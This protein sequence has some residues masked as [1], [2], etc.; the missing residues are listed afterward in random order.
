MDIRHPLITGTPTSGKTSLILEAEEAALLATSVPRP[1]ADQLLD[2][3]AGTVAIGRHTDG[4][5]ALLP[6]WN[7]YGAAHTLIA[8]PTGS[9]TSTLLDHLAAAEATTPLIDSRLIDG[10]AVAHGF[11]TTGRTDH[12]VRTA[13]ERGQALE[14]LGDLFDT[15]GR[16]R[17]GTD[18]DLPYAP[19]PQRPLITLTLTDWPEIAAD[20]EIARLAHAICVMGRSAGVGLRVAAWS[21]RLI[22]GAALNHRLTRATRIHLTA[23]S[24]PGQGT[25][26]PH[27]AA[28]ARAFRTWA[29]AA[30]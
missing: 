12:G 17:S 13:T 5:Q 15:I 4:S 20:E 21:V 10:R 22:D 25:L 28:P 24:A 9:G 23:R 6:L 16:R 30:R 19:T 7:Q 29:P 14:M 1:P 11:G 27:A 8:A 18:P 3:A 2:A 26:A